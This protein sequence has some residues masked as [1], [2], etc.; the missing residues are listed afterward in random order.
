MKKMARHTVLNSILKNLK[1]KLP[2]IFSLAKSL[3][4]K[5]AMNILINFLVSK[6]L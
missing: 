3:K 1:K 4:R 2:K 5:N 6:K